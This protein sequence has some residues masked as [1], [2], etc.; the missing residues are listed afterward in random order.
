[1]EKAMDDYK[2][3]TKISPEGVQE[4]ALKRR[5]EDRRKFS[6]EGFAYISI[7]GWICRRERCRRRDEKMGSIQTDDW[8]KRRQR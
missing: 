6:S 8:E 1:M 2:F 3:A 4:T 7:V 5:V